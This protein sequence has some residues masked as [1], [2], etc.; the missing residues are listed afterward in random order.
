MV[1]LGKLE[2]ICQEVLRL[3]Y[4]SF[5][6]NLKSDGMFITN[7]YTAHKELKK[8]MLRVRENI[9]SRFPNYMKAE[10][11]VQA[12]LMITKYFTMARTYG[13]RY[14]KKIGKMRD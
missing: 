3:E 6:R 4:R 8:M 11:Y 10:N 1:D 13:L 5:R 12:Q 7:N 14:G 9:E 2:K